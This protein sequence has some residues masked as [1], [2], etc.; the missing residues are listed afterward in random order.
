VTLKKNLDSAPPKIR[1]SLRD[2]SSHELDIA[3]KTREAIL[4]EVV[5][6]DPQGQIV[7]DG[8]GFL[9]RYE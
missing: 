1:V 3:G 5:K 9:S 6:L 8:P 4:Q 7:K 2:G